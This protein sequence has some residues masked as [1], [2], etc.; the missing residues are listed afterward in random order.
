VFDLLP[1]RE[2]KPEYGRV[3]TL[4]VPE[5]GGLLVDLERQVVIGRFLPRFLSSIAPRL[6]Q[7]RAWLARAETR[8]TT[9][10][11]FVGAL[12]ELG[13]VTNPVGE[14]GRGIK[15]EGSAKTIA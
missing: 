3:V 15:S 13:V 1:G 14:A 4:F 9:P 11:E 5:F 2:A 6:P 10:E 8:D 12:E 7:A